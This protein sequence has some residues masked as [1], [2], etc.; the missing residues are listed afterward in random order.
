MTSTETKYINWRAMLV[1]LR[2]LIFLAVVFVIFGLQ[3]QGILFRSA[4]Q[5]GLP[6]AILGAAAL[7]VGTFLTP[8]LLPWIPFHS[9]ALKDTTRGAA[10]SAG[11]RGWSA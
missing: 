2:F 1:A 8:L 6:V 9:F 4:W 11:C 3:P 5:N 7:L 10:G